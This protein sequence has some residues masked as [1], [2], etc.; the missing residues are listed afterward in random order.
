LSSKLLRTA[1]V[2]GAVVGGILLLVGG[3]AEAQSAGVMAGDPGS[4]ASQGKQVLGQTIDGPSSALQLVVL[5]TVA[6]LAPAIILTSTCFA[7]FAIVF[8]FVRNGLATQGAPPSQ[9]LVGMALF[10][11]LFVMAP[12][13]N[14]IYEE[15]L[16]PYL[17]GEI[18]EAQ[19]MKQGTPPLRRFLLERTNERDL[20]LFYEVSSAPRPN[21]ADDVPLRIAIP[22]FVLSELQ[23]AFKM[24]LV[25]LLPFL[26]IDLIVASVLSALGMVML[27]PPIVSL[28]IKLLVFV[29]VDGWHLVVSSLLRGVG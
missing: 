29:S 14:Q 15:A 19:A 16:R 13:G 2:G 25:V 26:V 3:V 18:S 27:P 12:T 10:M 21:Q 9:V 20:E 11:T 24:G 17:D 22:A 1:L 7:R 5:L 8:S 6:S 28:P 23:T 4:A